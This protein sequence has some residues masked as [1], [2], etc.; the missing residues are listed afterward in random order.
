MSKALIIARKSPIATRL[1]DTLTRE[2]YDVDRADTLISALS[3]LYLSPEA[4][5]V[6]LTGDTD[7][8]E[9]TTSEA[10]RLAAADPG[11]LGRHNYVALAS[12]S[13]EAEALAR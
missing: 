12:L 13:V 6:F 1:E 10:L 8:G 3:M 11:P 9:V 7:C 2:G 5:S 4:V